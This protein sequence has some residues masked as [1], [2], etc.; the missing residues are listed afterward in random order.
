MGSKT[1]FSHKAFAA[2]D[3][4]GKAASSAT[5]DTTAAETAKAGDKAGDKSAGAGAGK[6]AAD[7]DKDKTNS[8]NSSNSL[9]NFMDKKKG[10]KLLN[11]AMKS[12]STGTAKKK[13]VERLMDQKA[14]KQL[15][16]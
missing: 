2:M 6:A 4:K 11:G 8:T 9:S 13:L 10:E 15:K 1:G 7:K 3:D 14:K 5:G 16:K 12:A